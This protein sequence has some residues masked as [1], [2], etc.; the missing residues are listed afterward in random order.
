[1]DVYVN[2]ASIQADADSGKAVTVT[3]DST[4]GFNKV[5][6]AGTANTTLNGSD[7]ASSATSGKGTIYVRKSIPTLSAVALDTSTLSAGSNKTIA[8]FKVTADAAGDIAWAKVA[9][10]VQKTFGITLGATSTMQMW[11]GS[12]TV[13]GNFST[14]T[15]SLLGGL[16]AFPVVNGAAGTTD[17][18]LAFIPTAEQTVPAGTSLT[19]ELRTTVGGLAT[20][21]NSLD[22]SIAN[23]Q[24]TASTTATSAQVGTDANTTNSFIWSDKS[25][26]SETHALTTADWTDDYLVNTLPLT[27]G[28]MSVTI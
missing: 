15:G 25:R 4:G 10:K 14:T 2:L 1:M 16:Q 6:S 24:T 19:Y 12:N 9:F 28:N 5:D 27:V 22:V 26:V 7:L 21:G 23:A 13:A 3:L 18:N 17:L 20:A 8:R 11:Q